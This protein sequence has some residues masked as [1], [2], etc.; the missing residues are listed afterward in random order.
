MD[1]GKVFQVGRAA[2]AAGA[3][4]EALRTEI[5]AFVEA[6]RRDK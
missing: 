1:I 5:C 2:I 6:I 3:D 4:D